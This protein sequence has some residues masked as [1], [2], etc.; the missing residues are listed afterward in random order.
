L[1]TV[2]AFCSNT[3]TI[4]S[5]WITVFGNANINQLVDKICH[6]SFSAHKHKMDFLKYNDL[7]KFFTE[8]V[9]NIKTDMKYTSVHC[10]KVVIMKKNSLLEKIFILAWFTKFFQILILNWKIFK[11][12]CKVS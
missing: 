5:T 4:W 2:L 7:Q 6:A 9:A 3:R 1:T 11:I 12:H 8:K 10:E